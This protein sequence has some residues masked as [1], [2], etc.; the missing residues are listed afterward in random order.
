MPARKLV[1]EHPCPT[2]R[3]KPDDVAALNHWAA[4][5]RKA[6][7]L[8]LTREADVEPKEACQWKSILLCVCTVGWILRSS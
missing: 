2:Y 1:P 6:V 7:S 3:T 4:T 8:S 5:G